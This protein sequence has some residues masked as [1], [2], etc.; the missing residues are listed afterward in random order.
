L[1]HS[2]F[3]EF[4]WEEGL[5]YDAISIKTIQ[6]AMDNRITVNQKGLGRK[7]AWF[8]RG[9]VLQPHERAEGNHQKPQSG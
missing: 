3:V 1:G 6:A 5:F 4:F 9:T 2:Q 8:N 7:Q